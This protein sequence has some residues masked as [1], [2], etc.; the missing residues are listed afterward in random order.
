VRLAAPITD[1]SIANPHLNDDTGTII[2][3]PE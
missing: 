3:F 2:V 1:N